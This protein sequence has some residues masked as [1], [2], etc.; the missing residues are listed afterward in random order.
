[1]A[2]LVRLATMKQMKGLGRL[3]MAAVLVAMAPT[4]MG[5]QDSLRILH[6]RPALPASPIAPV[7]VDFDHPVAPRLDAS[8]DPARVLRIT[9][10]VGDPQDTSVDTVR[11]AHESRLAAAR[12]RTGAEPTRMASLDDVLAMEARVKL[13]KY[14]YRESSG[15]ITLDELIGLTRG[16][17]PIAEQIFREVQLIVERS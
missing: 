12:A 16:N 5:A 11:S 3:A 8:I 17:R 2:A 13:A 9:P 15:W 6:V 14:T 10:A 1:M 7:V 4:V